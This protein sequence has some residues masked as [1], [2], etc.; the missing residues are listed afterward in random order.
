MG[1]RGLE[2]LGCGEV[3]GVYYSKAVI[4]N[5]EIVSVTS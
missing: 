4:V 5:Q 2:V 1:F 3:S